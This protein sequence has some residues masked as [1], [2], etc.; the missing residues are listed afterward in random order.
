MPSSPNYVRDIAQERRTAIARGETGVGHKSKDATRHRARRIVA[1]RL[2]HEIPK[3]KQVDHKLPLKA[4]GSN[5]PSNLRLLSTHRNESDGGKMGNKAGK[6]AGARK[7]KLP[8][9]KP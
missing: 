7:G 3:G 9:R 4:G 8:T 2:G 6:A 5:D 1:K